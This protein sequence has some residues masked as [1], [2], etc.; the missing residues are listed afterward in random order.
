MSHEC[1]EILVTLQNK[2]R[3]L[4]SIT[5]CLLTQTKLQGSFEEFSETIAFGMKNIHSVLLSLHLSIVGYWKLQ[6]KRANPLR[7]T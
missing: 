3:L 5:V 7:Q 1:Y 6:C 4:E 2:Y